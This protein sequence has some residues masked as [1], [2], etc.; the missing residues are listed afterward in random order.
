LRRGPGKATDDFECGDAAMT[1]AVIIM[2]KT[3]VLRA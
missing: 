1:D 3:T 2:S